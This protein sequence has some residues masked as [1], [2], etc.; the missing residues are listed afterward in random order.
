MEK[1]L[2]FGLLVLANCISVSAQNGNYGMGARSAA[3]GGSSITIGDE[4]AL[5]NN[6]GGL[7]AIQDKM[8]FTSVK[9][10]YGISEFTSLAFGATYP[11]AGGT[12]GLGVFRFGD[13]LFNEQRLNL[14]FS[15]QFGIVSLGL[16]VSYYQLNIEGAGSRKTL[17]I[18]FGGRAKL[19]EQLLFGAHVSNLNQAKLSKVTDERIPT[20]MK[21]GLSYR[22]NSDLMINAEVEKEIDQE[23]LLKLGLEYKVLDNFSI[24]TG[25][26]T[27]P[28]ESSF[29]L[30][31]HPGKLN[32]N[33]AYINNPDLGGIHEISISYKFKD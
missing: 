4:W 27:Q 1:R 19:T 26:H 5:F 14:G 20:I 31:F 21:T 3:L 22:P 13:D 10:K 29:G 17:L 28:F 2:L 32:A 18:D 8:I 6:I 23:A 12:A 7:A 11:I 30:G 9:N 33:Y 24:R 15:N 25:F 16:N